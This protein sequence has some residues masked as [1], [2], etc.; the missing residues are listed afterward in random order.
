MPL[1]SART[2]SLLA[3]IGIRNANADDVGYIMSRTLKD[4]RNSDFCK[5]APNDVAYLYLHR[6]LEHHLTKDVVRVAYPTATKGTGNTVLQGD[7]K[8]ILGYIIAMPSDL[9][10]VVHYANTRKTFEE[11]GVIFE[12]Y[13]Q[14]GICKQLVQSLLRDYDLENVIY[15]QRTAQF[16]YDKPWRERV[17][18]DSNIEHNPWLFYTLL[19]PGW[20]TGVLKRRPSSAKAFARSEAQAR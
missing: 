13:R 2:D 5:G 19:P 7:H 18:H 3:P 6:A 1:D 12:D 8:R 20:E 10:L 4:L 17:D 14:Q 11:D 15:T 9:G 16:R